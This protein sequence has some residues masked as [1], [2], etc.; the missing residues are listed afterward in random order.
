MDKN[1]KEFSKKV[2]DGCYRFVDFKFDF[3]GAHIVN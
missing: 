1:K 2:T 3:K